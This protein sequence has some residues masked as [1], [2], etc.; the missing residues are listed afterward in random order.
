MNIDLH[1]MLVYNRRDAVKSGA[2]SAEKMLWKF[3][4][5]AMLNRRSMNSPLFLKKLMVNLFFKK[6]W[7]PRRDFPDFAAESFNQRWKKGK[8]SG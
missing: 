6:A 1:K 7:G 2:G 8:L 4:K 3:W 5:K